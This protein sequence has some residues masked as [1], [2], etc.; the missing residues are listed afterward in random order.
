MLDKMALLLDGEWHTGWLPA[1]P[2]VHL[3]EAYAAL[4]AAAGVDGDGDVEADSG[5]GYEVVDSG[6]GY[7][8]I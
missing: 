1:E 6:N 5:G 7:D 8:S 4:V 2:V 3:A